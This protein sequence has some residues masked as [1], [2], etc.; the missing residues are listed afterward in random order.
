MQ[1]TVNISYTLLCLI[2]KGKQITFFNATL[3]FGFS[4]LRF[5]RRR[6]KPS[7]I[8]TRHKCSFLNIWKVRI[9]SVKIMLISQMF[10]QHISYILQLLVTMCAP[11][12]HV[13]NIQCYQHRHSVCYLLIS[14][15]LNIL[16]REAK[17]DGENDKIHYG[18][19]FN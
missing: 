4:F 19:T 18:S 15:S 6:G 10:L 7:K 12:V 16:R 3:N 14:S 11:Q 2:L 17:V 8:M 1:N 5:W 9:W 13:C